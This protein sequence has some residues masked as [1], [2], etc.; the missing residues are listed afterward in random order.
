MQ[1]A[2]A[3]ETDTGRISDW[4]RD[5]DVLD[6]VIADLAGGVFTPQHEF[7]IETDRRRVIVAGRD[8]YCREIGH[9]GGGLSDAD[10]TASSPFIHAT[11]VG[12][13]ETVELPSGHFEHIVETG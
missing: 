8:C 13:R 6:R 5:A 10:G 11:R 7:A 2:K 3:D 12:E 1:V 9:E 4:S